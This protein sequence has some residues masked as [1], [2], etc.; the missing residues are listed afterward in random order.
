MADY[1][2][3]VDYYYCTGCH[4]CEVACKQEHHIPAGK[5]AGIKINELVQDLPGGKLDITYLPFF[6]KLCYF[7]APR[8]KQGQLPTCVKHCMANCLKFGKAKK[9]ASEVPEKGKRLLYTMKLPY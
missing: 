3:L 1:G 2:I 5:I 9:L 4:A 7:C 6:T 8:I